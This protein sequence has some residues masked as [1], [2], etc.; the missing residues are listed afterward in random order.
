MAN[1]SNKVNSIN[2]NGEVISDVRSSLLLSS[3]LTAKSGNKLQSWTINT[4]VIDAITSIGLINS[5]NVRGP[6][7]YQFY[8][9]FDTL[10][11]VNGN[12]VGQIVPVNAE[13]IERIVITANSPTRD[14]RPPRNLKLTLNGCF[15]EEQLRT[16]AQIESIRT[17]PMRGKQRIEVFICFNCF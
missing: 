11:E 7:H 13:N 9:D 6:I 16:K 5:P 4:S 12:N 1:P 3:G 14:G 15:R 8:D 2:L 10:I 17:S